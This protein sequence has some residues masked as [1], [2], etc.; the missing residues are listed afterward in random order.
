M[1]TVKGQINKNADLVQ[2]ISLFAF[3]GPKSNYFGVAFFF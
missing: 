3:P 1:E 2:N